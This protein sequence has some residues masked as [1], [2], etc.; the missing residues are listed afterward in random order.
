MCMI[1]I[2]KL[3]LYVPPYLNE[4]LKHVSETQFEAK[5]SYY[6]NSIEKL[7]DRYIRCI[8]LESN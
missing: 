3:S 6:K 4:K 7:D 2:K 8:I 1:P 5:E